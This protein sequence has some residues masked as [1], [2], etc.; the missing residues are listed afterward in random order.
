MDVFYCDGGV[1]GV[2]GF[3][4]GSGD[5]ASKEDYHVGFAWVRDGCFG[6]D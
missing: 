1:K 4:Y 3:D 6:A 2:D 5:V